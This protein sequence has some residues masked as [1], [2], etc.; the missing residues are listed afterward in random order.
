MTICATA[1]KPIPRGS[2]DQQGARFGEEGTA[3]LICLVG[4]Y[5]MV[6]VTLNGFDVP[7]PDA[8]HT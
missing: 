3:E 5:C 6:A 8:A 4:L 1:S 7:V 2:R